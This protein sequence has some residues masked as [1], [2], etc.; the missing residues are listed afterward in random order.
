MSVSV[1]IATFGDASWQQLAQTAAASA[2]DQA[3]EILCVHGDT[4]ATARNEGLR[5]A[6]GEYVIHLDADDELEPGYV[7][8]MLTGTADIRAPAV[9]YVQD[10]R[11]RAP[12]VPRVAGHD[13]D[14]TADCLPHG[15]FIAVGALART[16]V[17]RDAGG[18]EDW[19]VYEDWALFLRC[20]KLGA[21][22]EAIPDAVYRAAW[23]PDSRNRAPAMVEK[24]RVHTDI[25][26]AI[27]G[28]SA[29]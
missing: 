19:P 28:E 23:R 24:N 5:M 12:R 3:D 27:L 6:A 22:V 2:E 1:V 16:Q 29:A 4:L 20:W 9:R 11:V 10:G 13:H 26:A 14:C 25:V 21:S 7:T 8:A 18:W 15:N 17:L